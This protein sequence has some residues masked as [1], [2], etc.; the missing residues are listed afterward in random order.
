MATLPE[1]SGRRHQ[2][3][4]M[5]SPKIFIFSMIDDPIR[6]SSKIGFD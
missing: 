2:A 6:T 3:K 4:E 1:F 5:D